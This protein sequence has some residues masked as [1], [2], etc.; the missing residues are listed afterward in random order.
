MLCTLIF[1]T[2]VKMAH[3]TVQKW[4]SRTSNKKRVDDGATRSPKQRVPTKWW[5]VRNVNKASNES[6][7]KW[8]LCN[9]WKCLQNVYKINTTTKSL[10][11]LPVLDPKC[12]SFLKMN[13]MSDSHL[14]LDVGGEC[15]VHSDKLRE[16]LNIGCCKHW[17]CPGDLWSELSESD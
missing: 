11:S 17:V 10:S 1:L 12:T 4:S 16:V 7:Y 8:M 13:F 6:S 2:N 9:I 3:L 5:F 14:T 15:L